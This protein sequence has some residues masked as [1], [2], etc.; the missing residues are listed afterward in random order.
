[1][2]L[3]PHW[4]LALGLLQACL[5][6]PPVSVPTSGSVV[7]S[8][9]DLKAILLLTDDLDDVKRRWAQPDSPR[10]KTINRARI[11]DRVYAVLVFTGC[12]PD[13]AGLCQLVADYVITDPGGQTRSDHGRPVCLGKPPPPAGLLSIGQESMSVSVISGP[14]GPYAVRAIVRDRVSGNVIE[15]QLAFTLQ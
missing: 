1:M 9:G 2:R 13:D 14:L 7:A 10:L 15:L 8:K 11:G 6:A 12:T 5:A 4:A 3:S